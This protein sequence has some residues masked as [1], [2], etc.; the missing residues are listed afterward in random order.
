MCVCIHA[1]INFIELISATIKVKQCHGTARAH[2]KDQAKANHLSIT[3]CFINTLCIHHQFIPIRCNNHSIIHCYHHSLKHCHRGKH[4]YR[5]PHQF[6]HKP[7]YRAT[8]SVK[9]LPLKLQHSNHR[10][11]HTIRNTN[12]SKTKNILSTTITK[13]SK[14]NNSNQRLST[15][16]DTT[17]TEE[18][19]SH[20]FDGLAVMHSKSNTIAHKI[21]RPMNG[22]ASA[23]FHCH[24]K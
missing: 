2:R 19:L 3:E 10:K 11:E 1:R 13:K 15:Y 17:I 8:L 12:G 24:S 20:C 16:R 4:Q 21:H 18:N 22:T 6:H 14:N 9:H 23:H 5:P 7:Q